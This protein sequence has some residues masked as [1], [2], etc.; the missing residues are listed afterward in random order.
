M[1]VIKLE[2]NKELRKRIDGVPLPK[3]KN[4]RVKSGGYGELEN[5]CTWYSFPVIVDPCPQSFGIS[6]AFVFIH[7]AVISCFAD[8]YVKEYRPPNFDG[9]KKYGVLFAV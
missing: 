1:T 9:K 6:L 3:V 4:Y 8:L 5:S 2:D 7:F